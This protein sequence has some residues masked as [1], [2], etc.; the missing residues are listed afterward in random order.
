MNDSITENSRQWAWAHIWPPAFAVA[1]IRSSWPRQSSPSRVADSTPKVTGTPVLVA[2]SRRRPK[3]SA[4]TAGSLE[5]AAG[6]WAISNM[7]APVSPMTPTSASTS[8]HVASREAT[9]RSSAV[10][11]FVVARW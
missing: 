7:P 8:S 11:W 9:G 2:R 3:N 4:R 5:R 1:S 10:W 6:S